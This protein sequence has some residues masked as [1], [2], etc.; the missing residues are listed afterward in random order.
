MPVRKLRGPSL[1]A[2][3]FR[4]DPQIHI[5]AIEASAPPLTEGQ[6]GRKRVLLWPFEL[7]AQGVPKLVAL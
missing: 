6:K 7:E 1:D 3:F 2:A 5:D 4:P